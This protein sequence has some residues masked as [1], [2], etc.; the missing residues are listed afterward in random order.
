[1]N[2]LLAAALAVSLRFV[3]PG[4]PP[5]DMRVEAANVPPG[6]A[7]TLHLMRDGMMGPA[8]FSRVMSRN[9][10]LILVPAFPL[11]PGA[12]YRASLRL[13]DGRKLEADHRM[14]GGSP[15][16]APRVSRILPEVATVPANLLKFY[17]EFTE[18]MREGREVFDLIRLMDEQG[19]E[20]PSPWRRQELWSEDAR[21][22][23]L[24]IH[25]GRIK[26]GVNLRESMGPV[27]KPGRRYRLVL[28]GRLRGADGTAMGRDHVHAFSTA[29]EDHDMPDPRRW[30][31]EPPGA[32]TLRA[33]RVTGAEPLD[34]ALLRRCQWV[35][36]ALGEKVAATVE[37]ARG[38]MAWAWI[39]RHPWPA[40]RYHLCVN[41][42]L[43]DLAGNTPARP[44]E[45]DVNEPEKDFEN[46]RLAFEIR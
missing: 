14:P 23:S 21:R 32:G 2:T 25:P 9:G 19:L 38:G 31:I 1:M 40:G 26:R 43:E 15:G 20:V 30:R 39:P 11:E 24:W 44:F 13:P 42:W 46:I 27:L 35:E 7:L 12:R 34:Q 6:A 22:L 18:P 4:S 8:M 37:I 5:S 3:P 29:A 17:L 16:V 36:D 45:R 41:E 33:L 10:G 28:D